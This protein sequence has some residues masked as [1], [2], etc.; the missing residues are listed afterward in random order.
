MKANL[1][2]GAV[3]FTSIVAGMIIGLFAG[4]Y[5]YTAWVPAD[6]ILKNASPKYLNSDSETFTPQYRD[7]YVVR[8][9]EKYQRDLQAGSADPLRGAYDVLGVTT[10]DTSIDE[11]IGMTQMTQK[12]VTQDINAHSTQSV[13]SQ[14]EE[15]AIGSLMSALTEAKQKKLYPI[16]DLS[17]YGP[18]LA[19]TTTR[20]IGFVLLLTLALVAFL[21]ILW[22]DRR[23]SGGNSFMPTPIQRAPRSRPNPAPTVAY[24]AATPANPNVAVDASPTAPGIIGSVPIA[25]AATPAPAPVATQPVVEETPLSTFAPTI[26]RHGDDHFDEDFAV[27]GPMGELIGECGASIADRIGVDTPAR[28]SALSLWVFDKN[29]FQSTTKVLMTDF[30]W[31]DPV[32]RGKL[33]S[34]GDAVLAVNGGVVEIL[35]TMLRVEVQVKDLA[36]NTDNNPPQGYFQNVSLTFTVYK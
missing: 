18:A 16:V 4:V 34:R 25:A 8:A 19:R 28:V 26:Y 10:G 9:A 17:T 5:I 14:N 2:R 35:T 20:L 1:N 7:F 24:V 23:T 31:N 22:V 32:I 33:K 3:I 15:L 12:V 29:D 27:N 6:T 21:V 11:A 30:A 13:F 36:L